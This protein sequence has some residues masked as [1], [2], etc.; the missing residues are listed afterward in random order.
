M[1][2][3]R[4]RAKSSPVQSLTN[5]A[6]WR[7]SSVS[8]RVVI[9][10]TS[11]TGSH[12]VSIH[13]SPSHDP[14]AVSNHSMRGEPSHLEESSGARDVSRTIR[15]L[16]KCSTTSESTDIPRDAHHS[17]ACPGEDTLLRFLEGKLEVNDDARIVAHVEDCDACQGCLERLTA[18]PAGDG[19]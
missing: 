16:G 4:P 8:A 5:R 19:H 11:E 18:R 12:R 13:G 1:T 10:T 14:V 6:C 2:V 7:A 3:R 15:L 17:N 9:Q